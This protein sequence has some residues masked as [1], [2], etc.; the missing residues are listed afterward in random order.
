MKK[1]LPIFAVKYE[2]METLLKVLIALIAIIISIKILFML[3]AFIAS[4]HALNL[5][6]SL[7]S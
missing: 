1:N 7:P 4:L 6:L 5:L 3:I 2:F